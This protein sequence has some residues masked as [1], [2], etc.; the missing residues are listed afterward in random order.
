M[1]RSEYINNLISFVKK[2]HDTDKL[3]MELARLL[4]ED[5]YMLSLIASNGTIEEKGW[6]K[7]VSAD[8]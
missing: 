2:Y 5:E 6:Y 1:E 4:S 7:N 3:M 8:G